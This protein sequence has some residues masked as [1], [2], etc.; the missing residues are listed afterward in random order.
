MVVSTVGTAIGISHA[1]ANDLSIR[2][3]VLSVEFRDPPLDAVDACLVKQQKKIHSTRIQ[4][5]I[6]G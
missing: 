5:V 2:E 6:R 3:T 4:S 1:E